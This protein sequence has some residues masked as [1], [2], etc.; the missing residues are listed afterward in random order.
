MTEIKP[1]SQRADVAELAYAQVSEACPFTR[2]RVQ[3][4][5]SAPNVKRDFIWEYGDY[6]WKRREY[7]WKH[8]E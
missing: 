8:G 1:F 3:V 5:P 7:V 6:A 2:L 4:P